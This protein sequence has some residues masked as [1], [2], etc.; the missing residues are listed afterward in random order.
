MGARI[1]PLFMAPQGAALASSGLPIGN[2]AI[3]FLTELRR[4]DIAA[5]LTG[6]S[7]A[8]CLVPVFAALYYAPTGKRIFSYQ[9]IE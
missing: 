4:P 3:V 9:G 6:K 2:S 1:V 5:N 7:S 8:D